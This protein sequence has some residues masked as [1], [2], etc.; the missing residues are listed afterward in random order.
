MTEVNNID[1]K[2]AA[3]KIWGILHE[4]KIPIGAIQGVFQTVASYI[5]STPIPSVSEIKEEPTPK[6]QIK[7]NNFANKL[8]S[9]ETEFEQEWKKMREMA[10]KAYERR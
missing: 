6:E 4:Y 1:I 7:S 8:K 9:H 3:L 2:N 10:I 5:S